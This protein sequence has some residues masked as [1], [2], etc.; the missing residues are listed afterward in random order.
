[1]K[2]VYRT[3]VSVSQDDLPLLLTALLNYKNDADGNSKK[4]YRK[5]L[6]YYILK[7]IVEGNNVKLTCNVS[8]AD[9]YAYRIEIIFDN[10][11]HAEN[12]AVVLAKVIELWKPMKKLNPTIIR[13]QASEK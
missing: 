3:N 12:S 7:Y 1:M 2:I 5:E 13:Q 11:E 6:R 9:G 4:P 10:N 8:V